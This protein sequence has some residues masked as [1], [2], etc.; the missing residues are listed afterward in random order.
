MRFYSHILPSIMLLFAALIS[1]N[2]AHAAGLEWTGTFTTNYGDLRLIQSGDR[3]YGDYGTRGYI[4]GRV[5]SAGTVMRGTFQ[6]NSPRGSHGFI[7]FRRSGSRFEGGWSWTA[8]GPPPSTKV[9]WTGNRKS[10]ARPTL[11]H[12][13]QKAS[14]WSDAWFK[15]DQQYRSWVSGSNAAITSTNTGT[16][17][18]TSQAS[19]AA[20][21]APDEAGFYPVQG[22]W[23]VT[24]QGAE[25]GPLAARRMVLQFTNPDSNGLVVG[26]APGKPLVMIGQRAGNGGFRGVWME[27][28]GPTNYQATGRWGVV[29]VSANRNANGSNIDAL[30]SVGY[31]LPLRQVNNPGVPGM[32]ARGTHLGGETGGNMPNARVLLGAWDRL[33]ARPSPY[34]AIHGIWPTSEIN[35]AIQKWVGNERVAGNFGT[36]QNVGFCAAKCMGNEP[37]A[38]ILR[39]TSIWANERREEKY[40][41]AGQIDAGLVFEARGKRTFAIPE[42]VKRVFERGRDN[43]LKGG[44]RQ[45]RIGL[46]EPPPPPSPAYQYYGCDFRRDAPSYSQVSFPLP[47]G[48]WSDPLTSI[49][50]TYGGVLAELGV[51]GR[52]QDVFR[53]DPSQNNEFLNFKEQ[54]NEVL[55]DN[56]TQ[57]AISAGQFDDQKICLRSNMRFDGGKR[58]ESAGAGTNVFLR[59]P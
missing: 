45:F 5:N 41:I 39:T 15:I 48:I 56:S 54:W 59:T 47:S 12:A 38:A 21:T 14:Y 51:N 36:T 16:S 3:V 8:N 42:R 52:N 26:R 22:N 49:R 6:Y 17:T 28:A 31:R 30:F 46:V 4:E 32:R 35:A 2:S 10:S 7:E 33:V 1:S 19:S 43:P 23:S 34:S 53:P 40:E 9:N 55:K 24:V 25:Y 27:T 11:K 18:E 37:V 20:A 57:A 44:S 29:R 58:W 13:V 50:F